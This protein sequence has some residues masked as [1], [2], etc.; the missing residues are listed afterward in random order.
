MYTIDCEIDKYEGN[1]LLIYYPYKVTNWSIHCKKFPFTKAKEEKR[2]LITNL[3]KK[4]TDFYSNQL[5]SFI[6]FE[7]EQSDLV[8]PIHYEEESLLAYSK[9]FLANYYI[10]KRKVW[11]YP[12]LY[13]MHTYSLYIPYLVQN[14]GHRGKAQGYLVE[15]ISGNRDSLKNYPEVTAFLSVKGVNV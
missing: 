14:E 4:Q 2:T 1:N 7:K 10:H 6:P 12:V 8:L 3:T 15:P 13:L 5:K 9:S 11:S